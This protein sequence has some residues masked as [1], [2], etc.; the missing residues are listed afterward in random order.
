[1]N[2]SGLCSCISYLL[3]HGNITANLASSNNSNLLCHSFCGSGVWEWLSWVFCLGSHKAAIKVSWLWSHLR[4]KWGKI[5]LQAHSDC[6]HHIQ[7]FSFLL[8]VGG[9]PPSAATAAHRSFVGLPKH[10]HSDSSK[11]E[12]QALN[13]V[14]THSHTPHHLHFVLLVR[15]KSQ[16]PPTLKG[17]E[18]T[19]A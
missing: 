15:R 7:C 14:H 6:W 2:T 18:S 8:A 16:I 12:R 3:P 4:S 1:M 17:R 13:H 5:C 19:R 9:R 10:G 11:R